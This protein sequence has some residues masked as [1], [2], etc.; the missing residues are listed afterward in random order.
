MLYCHNGG[1]DKMK[2]EMHIAVLLAIIGV[3]IGASSA[4]IYFIS[5]PV[6]EKVPFEVKVPVVQTMEVLKEVP[7]EVKVPVEV[8]KEVKVEDITKLAL[9][10]DYLQDIDEDLSIS[11]VLFES[12]AKAEAEEK[13]ASDMIEMIDEEDF[14]DS[15]LDDYRQS[16]VSVYKI[17][18][19][20]IV[21]K[22]YEDLD[23]ELKYEVKVKAKE[24]GEDR[25]YFM[26]NVTIPFEDAKMVLD[27][28]EVIEG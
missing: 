10:E 23:I 13:I 22:D 17:Y 14:F 21:S 6:V 16:E 8:I 12:K 15:V 3:I 26:F 9:I 4:G 25:E 27:D 28:I 18:D 2:S 11:Y 24:S 7:V 20:E 5:H 19:A 1:V